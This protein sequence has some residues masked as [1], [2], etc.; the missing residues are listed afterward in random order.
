MTF[1]WEDVQGKIRKQYLEQGDTLEEVRTRLKYE[2]GFTASVRAFKNKIKEWGFEKN[3]P[4]SGLTAASTSL[5]KRIDLDPAKSHDTAV[6][7]LSSS[8]PSI[9]KAA[10]IY[11]DN[12]LQRHAYDVEEQRMAFCSARD[13]IP[14]EYHDSETEDL[15]H[16]IEEV[17]KLEKMIINMRK[18]AS[19]ILSSVG[20]Q[21]RGPAGFAAVWKSE[22]MILE[23]AHGY[24]LAI[25]L[26]VVVSWKVFENILLNH[27]KSLAERKLPGSRKVQN[28]EYAIEDTSTRVPFSRKRSWDSFCRPGR[29]IDMSMIFKNNRETS[30]VCPKCNTI[31]KEKKGVLVECQSPHCK[32]Q[33]RTEDDEMQS[34][35]AAGQSPLGIRRRISRPTAHGP[36]LQRHIEEQEHPAMFKRVIIRVLPYA[37]IP[38]SKAS[39]QGAWNP[40]DDSTLRAARAQGMDW[41]TIQQ[42]YFPSKRPNDCRKRHERLMER[43]SRDGLKPE[44]LTT[45]SRIIVGSP[46]TPQSLRKRKL[47][48]DESSP[49]HKKRSS[50]TPSEPRR[51]QRS[52]EASLQH[53]PSP[54]GLLSLDVPFGYF[55]TSSSFPLPS[56]SAAASGPSLLDDNETKLVDSFFDGFSTDH[57]NYNFFDNMANGAELGPDLDEWL[58]TAMGATTSLGARGGSIGL[59][60][61]GIQ[62]QDAP[63]TLDT[64]HTCGCGDTC[65]CI[66]CAAHPYNDATQKYVRSAYES[67]NQPPTDG[68]ITSQLTLT[69]PISALTAHTPSSTTSGNDEEQ[70]LSASDFFFVNYTFASDGCGGNIQSCPCEDECECLGCTS[71]RQ[72]AIP[73]GRGEHMV[74]QA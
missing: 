65:Q 8:S 66:G 2:Y 52:E 16:A 58:P 10:L 60:E 34:A 7:L 63:G 17:K 39:I 9:A 48:P 35:K 40:S 54:L 74:D 36:S 32:M 25:P 11:V 61:K 29:K 12:E 46:F 22:P 38:Q 56:L 67:M 70:T 13:R 3:T 73:C 57:F 44:N 68:N 23:D 43:R 21:S 5:T 15:D 59:L 37:Q 64:V 24:V 19:N 47:V 20:E 51:T 30:V 4:R 55:Y 72:P 18:S 31:S 45:S 26:E 41:V 14:L 71:H 27:F 53:A 69:D 28:R 49:Q 62:H 42:A 1:K 6:C 33:F 50:L